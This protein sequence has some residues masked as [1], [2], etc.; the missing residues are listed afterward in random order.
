MESCEESVES[1]LSLTLSFP[2]L[3]C[4]IQALFIRLLFCTALAATTWHEKVR[5]ECPYPFEKT[6]YCHILLCESQIIKSKT[7]L[8]L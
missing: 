6:F 2:L 3:H 7:G 8:N 5:T 1:S 4:L